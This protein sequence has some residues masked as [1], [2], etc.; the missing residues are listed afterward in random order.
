MTD[1]KKPD[2]KRHPTPRPDGGEETRKAATS[3]RTGGGV[4]EGGAS[5][6]AKKRAGEASKLLAIRWP[7]SVLEGVEKAVQGSPIEF[8]TV[9]D[10]VKFAVLQELRRR[11]VLK[12]FKD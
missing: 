7:A 10:F 6:K 12:T 11:G 1:T 5:A 2:A 8:Q 3:R 9:T 4:A